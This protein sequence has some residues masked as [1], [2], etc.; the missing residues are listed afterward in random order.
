MR[1]PNQSFLDLTDQVLTQATQ[2]GV[3]HLYT[4]D[5]LLNG[6]QIQVQGR[7]LINFGSCSYLGLEL[8]TRLIKG[9]AE[10]AQKYGTQFSSS[11]AYVSS[12]QYLELE[13]LFIALF[14]AHCLVMPTT[15]LGHIS[16]L[17]A[18]VTP[19]DIIILDHQVHASVQMAS[20][21]IKARGDK[22]D[23]I[24]HNQ[25]DE[26]EE[27]IRKY[28]DTHRHIWYCIDGVY[29]MYGD[30]APMD[31]LYRLMDQYP[32]LYVYADDAHGFSW[33]GK[34]GRGTV[35]GSRT[36]HERLIVAVSLCKA[37]GAGGGLIDRIQYTRDLIQSHNLPDAA[38]SESPIFY[39]GV[40]QLQVGYNLVRRLMSE[41]HYVNMGLFPAVPV[42]RT[43]IRFTVTVHH[44]KSDLKA[45]V[46]AIAYHLPLALADEDSNL[47]EVRRAFEMQDNSEKKASQSQ[48]TLEEYDQCRQLPDVWDEL[49]G[50]QGNYDR[51]A[52]SALEQTF[53]EEN[54]S[55]HVNHWK[56]KY[57]IIRDS[58]N[59]VVLA[60]FA[61]N[62]C[63]KADMFASTEISKKAEQARKNNPYAYSYLTIMQ[64]SW[65]TEGPQLY[66]DR[67]HKNWKSAVTEWLKWMVAWRE[68]T[69]SVMIALRDHYGIDPE[70]DEL[71]Q[72]KSFLR[73][74]L[75]DSHKVDQPELFNEAGF[76]EKLSHDHRRH[77]RK[78]V[79]PFQNTFIT[80]ITEADNQ[81]HNADQLEH[82]YKLYRQ[83]YQRAL[84]INT[85]PLPIEYFANLMTTPGWEALELYLPN[86]DL[87]AAVVF[88]YWNGKKL[89]PLVIGMDYQYL[90]QGVYRQAL[91]QVMH[92]AKSLN[93]EPFSMGFGASLEKRRMGARAV[94]TYTYMQ[95]TDTFDLAA[96][97][98]ISD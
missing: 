27:R 78:A 92:R 47:S 55:N 68:Q 67:T 37:F 41:G 70:L 87:C 32:Q 13:S 4:E 83:V 66:L 89:C 17:P 44:K 28:R 24:R 85:F 21:L 1:Q 12:G 54:Q 9:C 96:L 88:Q 56:F 45:L 20:Q 14:N 93:S 8:D 75:P 95:A 40:G 6:R 30:L 31:E 34:K 59:Q 11:R 64:G 97:D 84:D 15:T 3:M 52:L 76:F 82:W 46:E 18:L 98:S 19:G 5:E 33:A 51:S 61:T 7:S 22:V 48:W 36:Q 77:W 38:N 50:L 57:L 65:L 69:G 53:C 86:E 81:W 10:A 29:S 80:R 90:N 23:M 58:Q 42:N 49:L 73:V 35:L 39:I 25:M 79:A 74:Q 91:F 26:L 72:G 2:E 62:V 94:E 16:A 43:G 71:L 63:I 60:T